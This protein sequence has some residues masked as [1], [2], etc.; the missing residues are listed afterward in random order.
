VPEPITYKVVVLT[1]RAL[2]A[3]Y[4]SICGNS[5][6]SPTCLLV[7]DSSPL[8]PTT[9][10]IQLPIELHRL[11][12]FSGSRSSHLEHV[13]SASSLT[14]FKQHLKLHLFRYSFPGLSPVWLLSGP[15]SVCCH[16]GHYT[17]LIDWLIDWLTDWYVVDEYGGGNGRV[18]PGSKAALGRC[19]ESERHATTST[20]D[21]PVTTPPRRRHRSPRSY[22]DDTSPRPSTPPVFSKGV[23]Q[24]TAYYYKHIRIDYLTELYRD[25]CDTLHGVPK[26]STV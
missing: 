9:W 18:T 14:V 25:V 2:P 1:Y 6:V 26:M 24:G 8:L 10:S 5:S 3:T 7:A 22:H 16:L 13:T 12:R 17:F 4:H 23:L 11:S 15:C 19:V 20:R 21:K